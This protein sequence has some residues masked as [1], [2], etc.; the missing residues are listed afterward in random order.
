MDERVRA[1]VPMGT[2]EIDA[3]SCYLARREMDARARA[4]TSPRGGFITEMALRKVCARAH[5][6]TSPATVLARKRPG[7][8]DLVY[9]TK[10]ALRDTCRHTCA[11]RILAVF[12]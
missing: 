12:L 7:I 5:G 10:I 3:S 1:R 11:N 8:L 6:H 2:P 4:P 9:I